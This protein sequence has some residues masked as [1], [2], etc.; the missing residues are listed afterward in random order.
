[1]NSSNQG[2]TFIKELKDFIAFLQNL[3]GVLAGISVLFPLSDAFF[4]IIPL[5]SFEE[6]G[7]LV[8][9]PRELFTAVATLV[10]LFLILRTFGQRGK[11][12]SLEER[13]GIGRGASLSFVVGLSALVVYL[14]LYFFLSNSAYDVL[15]WEGGDSVRLVGEVILLL[16]YSGLFALV[17]RAFVLL[18]MV[19]FFKREDNPSAA[20]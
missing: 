8:F 18:G 9:F 16:F 20:A 15:G 10:S 1:M 5:E 17:T 13:P 3:W 19:E 6:D 11:F 4:K 7:F 14:V 12:K 2:A